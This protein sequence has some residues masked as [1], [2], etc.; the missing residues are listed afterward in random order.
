MGDKISPSSELKLWLGGLIDDAVT[1]HVASQQQEPI[2]DY[3]TNL[4]VQFSDSDKIFFIRDRAG[5]PVR[6]VAELLAEGDIAQRADS[7]AR[8]R[9][10]H[11]HLGDFLLFGVGVFP[12]FLHHAPDEAPQ[13]LEAY[14]RL[15]QESYFVV[16]SFDHEPYNQEA[17]TY[18][19]LGNGFA[20]Y[21]FCLRIVRDQVGLRA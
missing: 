12:Q 7:F 4:L 15:G 20:D 1:R 11:R 17:A 13:N 18:R 9:E 10:V 21:A 19:S 14:C 8:E 16:S 5:R 3:L 2:I 6:E